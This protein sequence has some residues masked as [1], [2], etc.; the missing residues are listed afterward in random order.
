M[1]VAADL[2]QAILDAL[3]PPEEVASVGGPPD[4]IATLTPIAVQ[5][6]MTAYAQAIIDTLKSGD[7]SFASGLVTSAATPPGGAL[8]DGAATGGIISNMDPSVWQGIMNAAIP[9][10]GTSVNAEATAALAYIES[11]AIFVF[12]AGNITGTGTHTG[13]DPGILANGAG[14]GGRITNLTAAGWFAASG[15]AVGVPSAPLGA[16]LYTAI[17]DYLEANLEVTFADGKVTGT[18]GSGASPLANGAAVDGK[19]S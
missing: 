9:F 5:A 12:D 2:A 16:P 3:G 18:F 1:M 10:P 14:S 17:I 15:G 6:E 19:A 13:S 11:D 4:Y 7:I 8:V